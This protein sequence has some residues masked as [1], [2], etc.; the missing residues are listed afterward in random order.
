MRLPEPFCEF[1][2][3]ADGSFNYDELHALEYGWF[4]PY[5]MWRFLLKH[6]TEARQLFALE[7]VY[8]LGGMILH[9][10]TILL[11]SLILLVGVL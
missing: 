1:C 8:V 3:H 7:T 11:P 4:T 6:C 10:F 2:R 9:W 5:F